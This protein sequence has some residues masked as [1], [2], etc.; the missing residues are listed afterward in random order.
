MACESRGPHSLRTHMQST[1]L[2]VTV[3]A[4]S[5]A[6]T[7]ALAA[8]LN[9]KFHILHDLRNARGGLAPSQQVLDFITDRVTKKRVLTYHVWEDQA[10]RNRPNQPFLIFEG[11]T[12]SYAE[13]FDAILRVG[14]WLVNDLGV[15]VGEVVA[16]DGGNSPE[17]L[18]LWF[19]LDAIGASISFINWNLTG[20][21][22]VHCAKVSLKL[23]CTGL[24]ADWDA[25][26]RGETSHRGRRCE[27]QCRGQ[28]RRA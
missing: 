19:A 12:W 7:A 11:R 15:Q 23:V 20:T 28:S 21:G 2:T 1:R 16:I 24:F 14:N 17:Y 22:L 25:A 9:A 27:E 6:G 8:Y 13:F 3:I 26:L 4:A 18:M 5:A 10:L